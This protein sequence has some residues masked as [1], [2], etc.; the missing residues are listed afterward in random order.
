MGRLMSPN[1]DIL[2]H[3]PRH[4]PQVNDSPVTQL[5]NLSTYEASLRLQQATQTNSPSPHTFTQ[6]TQ[7]L[8]PRSQSKTMQTDLPTS[9]QVIIV[10]TLSQRR[11][12]VNNSV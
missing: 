7:T 6:I 3:S 4:E 1:K 10:S 12:K 9:P 5:Q 8:S 11:V 2:P